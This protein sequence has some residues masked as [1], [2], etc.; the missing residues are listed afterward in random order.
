MPALQKRVTSYEQHAPPANE[1]TAERFFSDFRSMGA[2]PSVYRRDET[3]FYTFKMWPP[4]LTSRVF[5]LHT[6]ASEQDK[7]DR[8]RNSY[9]K[10]IVATKP[11]GDFIHYLG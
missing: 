6:W 11:E 9:V 3:I 5:A 7:D 10:A 1:F 2:E 4:H 8:I